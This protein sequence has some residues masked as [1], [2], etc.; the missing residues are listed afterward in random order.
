M[1]L[2][3]YLDCPCPICGRPIGSDKRKT[4]GGK[5]C[6]AEYHARQLRGRKVRGGHK[7]QPIPTPEQITERV[8]E[9][10]ARHGYTKGDG[11]CDLT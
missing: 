5:A 10:D 2:A 7:R 3:C 11:P 6:I 4:C 9:I 8:A 1:T